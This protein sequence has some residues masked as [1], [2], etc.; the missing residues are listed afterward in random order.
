M[1]RH[2]PGLHSSQ[3]DATSLLEGLLLVRVDGVFFRWQPR[4]PFVE[5]RF[6]V[7]KP[8]ALTGKA[9]MGRFY[10]TDRA[11]WKFAW[12]LRDFGYDAE[13]LSHDEVDVRASLGLVGVV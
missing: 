10:Y 12:F 6:V 1:K 8:Q 7:L 9:F 13:L 5:V 11:L 2:I 3:T 4:K